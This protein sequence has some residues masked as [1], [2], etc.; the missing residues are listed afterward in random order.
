MRPLKLI[1][2]AFGPYAGETVLEM[3]KL[4]TNGLYLITGDTGA[5]KTSIFD[6]I[7]FALY[8]EASGDSREPSMF[9][10][11]YAKPETETKVELTFSYAG[12]TYRVMR[13]P[14]YERPKLRGE[15][16]TKQQA[17]AE[18]YYPD[19]RVIT[20]QREV[21][22]AIREL[23]GVSRTQFMQISM[24]AQGDF[25]KLLL[26]STDERKAIFRQIFKT[27]P[28][29]SIQDRLKR[30]AADLREECTAAQNSLSQFMGG[31]LADEDDVLSLEA[32][33]ARS[34]ELPV[35]DTLTLLRKLIGQDEASESSLEGK[36]EELDRELAAV[37][38]ILGKIEA[39]QK[40]EQ[41]VSRNKTLLAEE[42]ARRTA[43]KEALD[44]ENAKAPQAAHANDE[45]AKLEA[46]LI[47][48]DRLEEHKKKLAD[49]QRGLERMQRDQGEKSARCRSEEG[50]LSAW[51]EELK[52]IADA[53][54]EL[55]RLAAQKD[56][57]ETRKTGAERLL[58]AF[59]D[60]IAKKTELEALQKLYT[61]A[62]EQ[63][64]AAVSGYEQLN[65]AFLDEQAGLIAES[66]AEGQPC[67]VCG[68]LDH[69][70]LAKKSPHA[71]SEAQLK[72]AKRDAESAQRTA[73]EQ[74]ERCA[75][76]KAKLQTL[77]QNLQTELEAFGISGE[78][79]ESTLRQELAAQ[80]QELLRLSAAIRA[81]QAKVARKNELEQ[82]IPRQEALLAELKA[83]LEGIGKQYA[84]GQA[85][86]RTGTARLAEEK[87][88]LGFDSK[89]AAEMRIRTLSRMIEQWGDA[90]K[91]AQDRYNES[92][93]RIGELQAAIRGLT[94]QLSDRVELDPEQA[95]QRKLAL[96]Q[97]RRE[98][99]AEAK[100]LGARL[101]A[102]RSAMEHIEAKA[103][104]L[105]GLEKRYGMVRALSATAN[106][107]LTGKEKI[108]LETYI[109]MTFFD[110]II[111]RANTRLLVMSGNQYELK[112]C[113]E[114][115][116]KR[117]KSG[118][119][120]DVI[121]HYN[122]TER[123]VK[124]LSGGESFKASLSL[125]L[126]LSDE[127]QSSAGGV[128]LDTMFV[129]EGFGS[130]DEESLNQ[131]M[132][133]LCDLAEGNRLVGIISHVAEL[134]NRIDRQIVVTKRQSA[135]STAKI[136]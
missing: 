60:R 55:Q 95:Q 5:G 27:Q 2:S 78:G 43:L 65:K 14:E 6:A 35:A 85:E 70:C 112:R 93:K 88:S 46:E 25:L 16:L 52:T 120:L 30:D 77:T 74:S 107:N 103:G 89:L 39:Q 126:G 69:P 133:A 31:I 32:A 36:K 12:K 19:G 80:K 68:S 18:L 54:A 41:A 9:R 21:D 118:L 40:A 11:K 121:D 67:P 48:Y 75:A 134:K 10:S 63:S 37:N 97:A 128:R 108:M 92:D 99:D 76:A 56:K 106:G 7:T 130:L 15:G 50:K 94:E 83:E 57:A 109:Q 13:R 98:A 125:A 33:K 132:N 104:E 29:Q 71:P 101:A 64:R 73:Q 79:S 23:M 96:Q 123:S 44:A 24:I 45:R 61:A 53:G 129:D 22:Q 20:K 116:D 102:N 90:L 113:R 4:G 115:E 82:K 119:D 26:A 135:G 86:H 110:R 111:A 34:G 49:L 100:R 84:A 51:K 17:E 124:S 72:K 1:M 131:A 59:A 58:A 3:D 66:L 105:V 62:W 117:G 114:A 42:T 38:G 8:G 81:E 87:Q 136:V 122:G 91:K 28:F 127:I 47:R